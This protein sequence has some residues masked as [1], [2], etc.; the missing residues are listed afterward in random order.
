MIKYYELIIDYTA[1][2]AGSKG[3]FERYDQETKTFKT[4]K[5][6]KDFLKEKY[7]HCKKKS[8]MYIDNKDGTRQK[9]GTIYHYKNQF[10]KTEGT[11]FCQDWIELREVKAKPVLI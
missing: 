1:K 7:Y 2:Q 6:A 9:V 11:S 10:Y 3:L 4:I 5:K 8:N